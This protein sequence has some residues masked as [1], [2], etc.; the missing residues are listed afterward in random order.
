MSGFVVAHGKSDRK[1]LERMFEKIGH[2]G[3]YV[4]GTSENKQAM[5]ARNYL[6]R[7]GFKQDM[8]VG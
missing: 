2:R 4:S 1:T 5:M 7:K 6:L 8:S 3:P